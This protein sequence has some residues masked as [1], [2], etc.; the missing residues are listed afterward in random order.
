MKTLRKRVFDKACQDLA[1][2]SEHFRFD[3]AETDRGFELRCYFPDIEAYTSVD[4]D[5]FPEGGTP[6]RPSWLT[7]HRERYQKWL[8]EWQQAR[9]IDKIIL[10]L[11]ESN[12]GP[13]RRP[14]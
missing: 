11:K 5:L 4:L 14:R 1:G 2:A 10:K 6:V 8:M 7:R 9:I 3:I 13:K 12:D